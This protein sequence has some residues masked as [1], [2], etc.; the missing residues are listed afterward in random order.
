[1]SIN[2]RQY[3]LEAIE[4]M[5]GSE[6]GSKEGLYDKYRYAAVFLPTGGGKSFVGMEAMNRI[7]ANEDDQNVITNTPMLYLSP[8]EGII[9]QYQLHMAEHMI[10][11]HHISNIDAVTQEN[12]A[13][14]VEEI[15][16][17]FSDTVSIN[18]DEIEEYIEKHTD[19]DPD[20]LLRM[21]L[22]NQLGKQSVKTVEAGVQ[23]AFPNLKFKCYQ[24]MRSKAIKTDELDESLE[25]NDALKTFYVEDIDSDFIIFDEAHRGGAKEWKTRIDKLITSHKNTRFLTITATPDRDE[26]EQS[27]M[28]SI[29]SKTGYSVEDRRNKKYVA[30]DYKLIQAMQDGKVVT[31]DVVHF[32]CTLDQ[33]SEYKEVRKALEEAQERSRQ[34]PRNQKASD[35][36]QM[37]KA[38]I[39]RMHKL[40]GRPKGMSDED[41]EVEQRSII[42]KTIKDSGLNEHGKYISFIPKTPATDEDID[43]SQRARE[44]V[45]NYEERIKSLLGQA[46]GISSEDVYAKGYHSSAYTAKENQDTLQEFVGFET[47]RGPAKVIITCQKLNEGVHVDSTEGLFMFEEIAGENRKT[48]KDDPKIRFLQQIGR[49]ITS[50][51]EEHPERTVVPKIFDF[52]H[53]FMRQSPMLLTENGEQYFNI[54][55]EQREFLNLYKIFKSRPTKMSVRIPKGMDYDEAVKRDERVLIFTSKIKGKEVV[56]ESPSSQ[57]EPLVLKRDISKAVSDP[58]IA[59]EV[60]KEKIT[61]LDVSRI[62]A[63]NRYGYLTKILDVLNQNGIDTQNLD[64]NINLSKEFLEAN[65][66]KEDRLSQVLDQLYESGV[67]KIVDSMDKTPYPI[68]TE[69]K[70]FRNAF[71]GIGANKAT[72]D[73]FEKENI[74]LQKL[75]RIGI[76]HVDLTNIPEELKDKID[77]RG[78]IIPN[79]KMA[80]Q[81]YGINIQTGTRYFEG[82]DEFGCDEAGYDIYGYDKDGFNR[83]GIHKITGTHY[84]E[85]FF[86][87]AVEK[88]PKT[89]EEVTVW[90]NAMN[91]GVTVDRLGYN[92]DGINPDTGFDRGRI[93]NG[94]RVH[95]WHRPNED[96]TF[97]RRGTIRD[98]NGINFYGF[99]GQNRIGIP[100]MGPTQGAVG[101]KVNY[102]N[103]D[104]Q[105][106]SNKTGDY[107]DFEGRDIERFDE[108][109]FN[110]FGIN[111]DTSYEYGLDAKDVNG[112]LHPDVKMCQDIVKM[113][114]DKKMTPEQ[115]CSEFNLSAEEIDESLNRALTVYGMS[116]DLKDDALSSR[117]T[118]N[119]SAIDTLAK[120]SPSMHKQFVQKT[121]YKVALVRELE[122]KKVQYRSQGEKGEKKLQELTE[123]INRINS[124][125]IVRQRPDDEL[126]L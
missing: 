119:K 83:D 88:D 86:Y 42:V 122:S 124:S 33:T 20:R 50:I 87:K 107:R 15:L 47:D 22:K 19:V 101:S 51:D 63:K 40:M 65:G 56:M 78:F 61:P 70:Y 32:S 14:R 121:Q 67:R 116:P 74:D 16:Q 110:E 12:L 41:W 21:I 36:V 79:D 99:D 8:N 80:E 95:Y 17:R 27:I 91:K 39:D 45:G 5:F 38:I 24:S 118:Q 97:S 54:P 103:F 109:G 84:D 114:L 2:L 58:I 13:D 64:E 66:I 29:A 37:Y 52:A 100:S 55:K 62:N 75:A 18:S 43:L 23:K 120:L 102:Y 111:I 94:I 76:L 30:K 59:K 72:R 85:R 117:V 35:T 108:R 82:R 90:R 49:C 93:I 105:R 60:S 104:N 57:P 73:I 115:V 53:N 28:D 4:S 46:L 98:D 125:N 92:H 6:D 112:N 25:E 89:G 81:F 68:G 113:L 96:G 31:P 7:M 126:E 106:K 69:M 44:H 9:Y 3:Q 34:N 26:D 11:E 123:R 77:S 48:L 71:F 10:F 1:M